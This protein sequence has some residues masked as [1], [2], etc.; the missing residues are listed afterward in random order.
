[1]RKPSISVI[2]PTYNHANFI[3][4]CLRS[5]VAQSIDSWEAIVVNN[6]S[7]DN[8]LDVINAV[9]DSRI[10]VINFKNNG[11]IAASR[12]RGIKEA[13]GRYIAFLDSDDWWLPEKLSKALSRLSKADFVHHDLIIQTQS[14]LTK[15]LLKGKQ[16]RKPVFKDLMTSP[17]V[18]FNSSVVTHKHLLDNVGGLSESKELVG[19][20]DTDLWLRLAM[21]TDRF[22]HIP[23]SLGVYWRRQISLLDT[24]YRKHEANVPP[25]AQKPAYA[26]H[27]YAIGRLLSKM[28]RFREA[29]GRFATAALN[30]TVPLR[31][32]SLGAAISAL[33]G[34]FTH[35][36]RNR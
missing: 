31:I 19:G 10:R 11:I 26:I 1:M 5:V 25:E 8:T 23:E 29:L 12:N 36:G 7:T 30:G 34:L 16:L 17:P 15:T 21:I 9:G 2:I 14:G 4:R 35:W 3:D 18:V 28:N 32:K 20:E 22:H 24:L 6:Y 33:F 27:N 13:L